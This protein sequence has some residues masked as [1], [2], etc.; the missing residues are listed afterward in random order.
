MSGAEKTGCENR[1]NVGLRLPDEQGQYA[2][3]DC[4]FGT[5]CVEPDGSV[6]AHFEGVDDV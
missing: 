6:V 3:D 4:I 2:F 1:G 5:I